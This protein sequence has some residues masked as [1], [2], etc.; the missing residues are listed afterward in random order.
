MK[1]IP[2]SFISFIL[3]F[4]T[5][6]PAQIAEN[7]A[8]E[9]SIRIQKSQ[10]HII[11]IKQLKFIPDYIE[12]NKGDTITFI[13]NDYV[14]HDVTEEKTKKWSSSLM[15]K[16]SSWSMVAKEDADYYCTLHV[17]MK[18]KIRVKK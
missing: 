4:F 1:T 9:S 7:Q 10:K 11:E 2:I 17:I 12:V 6:S 3:L 18:G 8:I 15:K 5:S 14:D 16:G 13:N